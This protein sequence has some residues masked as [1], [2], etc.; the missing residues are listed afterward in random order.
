M[1][2]VADLDPT[3]TVTATQTAVFQQASSRPADVPKWLLTLS[4]ISTLAALFVFGAATFFMVIEGMGP[5][6]D[7]LRANDTAFIQTE[8]DHH[9]D[10][11]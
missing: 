9:I 3:A 2:A 4:V 11:R 10:M 8:V 6:V 5:D 1:G 7:N